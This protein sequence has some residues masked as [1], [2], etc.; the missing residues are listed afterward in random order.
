VDNSPS[1]H[2]T[3]C[4]VSRRY[5]TVRYICEPRPGFN[6]ARN[7]AI[8]E[9]CG[10][11]IAYTVDDVVVDSEWVIAISRLFGENPEVMA[12]T[13]LVVPYELETEAQLFFEEY[14][15]FR[16]GFERKWFRLDCKNRKKEM[17]HNDAGRLGTGANMAL[18]RGLF[19][20]ISGFDSALDVGTV[21]NV[22]AAH[23]PA[24]S[25]S[26]SKPSTTMG[27]PIS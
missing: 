5:P 24:R 3:E 10:E 25:F 23:R 7:R 4:L 13:G 11:V 18:R 26:N 21:T 1:S 17:S 20:Q 12:D 2:T 16:K 15:G 14:S 22:A 27:P 8:S 6:W 9:A 19:Q